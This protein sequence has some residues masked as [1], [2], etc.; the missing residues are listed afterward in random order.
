MKPLPAEQRTLD[1]GR[2][3]ALFCLARIAF[4][5]IFMIYSAALP[6]LTVD[7]SMTATQAGM[8]QS[9]WHLGYLVS[10]FAVGFLGGPVWSETDLHLQRRGRQRERI[11]FR[12][13]LVGVRFRGGSV[14]TGRALL[15]RVLHTGSHPSS[16]NAFPP[17]P[18]GEPWVSTSP[19]GPSLTL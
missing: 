11:D 13:I 10:L 14:R 19:R 6:L 18:A 3:L 16:R 4:S 12:R 8:I 15:G 1:D 2:W 9:S 5:F 7:W 17:P